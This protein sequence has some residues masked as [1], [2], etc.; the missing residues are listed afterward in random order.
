MPLNVWLPPEEAK[1]SQS[2]AL[3]R[4]RLGGDGAVGVTALADFMMPRMSIGNGAT[5]VLDIGI[6]LDVKLDLVTIAKVLCDALV[7]VTADLPEAIADLL[8]P[9]SA[10]NHCEIHLLAS[11]SNGPGETRVNDISERI[12]LNLLRREGVPNPTFGEQAGFAAELSQ[13]LSLHDA[14]EL[15]AYGLNYIALSKGFLDPTRAMQVVRE[16][17]GLP[18]EDVPE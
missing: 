12:D 7:A 13:P 17:L 3:A 2:T 6:S 10:V 14:A 15:V 8:P 16:G 4:Y 5:F 11:S 18:P 9:N 1:N